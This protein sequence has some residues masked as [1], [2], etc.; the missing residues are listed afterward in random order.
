[1]W[2]GA[3]VDEYS[4]VAMLPWLL[5]KQQKCPHSYI[6]NCVTL[7]TPM[8]LSISKD[9]QVFFTHAT[10]ISCLFLF[11][12]SQLAVWIQVWTLNLFLSLSISLGF[13]LHF[14]SLETVKV[15]ILLQPLSSQPN[16]FEWIKKS[17]LLIV[18]TLI[19]KHEWRTYHAQKLLLA[20]GHFIILWRGGRGWNG[21]YL[22]W[23]SCK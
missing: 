11:L 7:P 3:I 19:P 12:L 14:L 9:P 23:L 18:N 17:V 10:Q 13:N 2:Y 21:R 15:L 5:F 1:M 16:G 20:C 6:G 8:E 22:L 4:P